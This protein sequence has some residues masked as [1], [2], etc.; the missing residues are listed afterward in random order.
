MSIIVGVKSAPTPKAL[1][2]ESTCST[3]LHYI[4]LS[5]EMALG[6]NS[7]DQ[8]AECQGS[9]MDSEGNKTCRSTHVRVCIIFCL[10]CR[11]GKNWIPVQCPRKPKHIG[12]VSDVCEV[13]PPC[14]QRMGS[15]SESLRVLAATLRHGAHER[16]ARLIRA[17]DAHCTIRA[18][19]V[20]AGIWKIP[21]LHTEVP[22]RLSTFRPLLSPRHQHDAISARTTRRPD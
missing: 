16:S 11:V 14:T 3:W 13:P 12:E 2:E 10:S 7:S 6:R 19:T 18:W 20:V 22:D 15:W 1:C 8:G 21:T 4:L 9:W 5:L 17:H